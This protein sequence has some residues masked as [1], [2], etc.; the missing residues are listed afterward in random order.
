MLLPVRL[1]LSGVQFLPHPLYLAQQIPH[2]PLF[3]LRQCAG[4]VYHGLFPHL[5]CVL[6][7]LGRLKCCLALHL[8]DRL[9]C[10]GQLLLGS[11]GDGFVH[12]LPLLHQPR[13]LI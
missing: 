2:G 4:C 10:Q 9:E 5:E 1:S 8:V 11:I 7:P 12:G 3:R 13:D 6:K